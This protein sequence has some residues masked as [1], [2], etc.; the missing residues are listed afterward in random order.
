MGVP[1]YE[2]RDPFMR[3]VQV[4]LPVRLC[5]DGV[6]GGVWKSLFNGP[7]LSLSLSEASAEI[8]PS[9][10]LRTPGLYVSS[11]LHVVWIWEVTGWRHFASLLPPEGKNNKIY[12]EECAFSALNSQAR[13]E[14]C[15]G[16]WKSRRT[17]WR[18][19]CLYNGNDQSMPP[20]KDDNEYCSAESGCFLYLCRRSKGLEKN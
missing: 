5:F 10:F 8:Y 3:W 16:S 11:H 13:Q 7:W 19:A 1:F 6:T 12:K 18:L 20:V 4:R 9:D 2:I 17:T 15:S 14:Q